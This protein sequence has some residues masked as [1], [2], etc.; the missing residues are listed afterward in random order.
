[1]NKPKVVVIAGPTASGK[2]ALAVELAKKINGEI[3]SADSMQIYKNM[4]IG[5]AKISEDEMQG[6]RHY[7]LDIIEPDK[8]Y[9]VSD[10]K[11]D[12]ENYIEKIIKEGKTPIICGGTGLYINSLIYGI[13]FQE[14]KI[15]QKYRDKLNKIADDGELEKL[16]NEA[17]KIDP[18][19]TKKI[20]KNDKKRII[21]ILEIY[22]TTGKTKTQQEIESKKGEIKYNYIVF[23]I[24]MK[25]ELLYERINKRVDQMIKNGLIEE[26]A[27]IIKKYK[28]FPTAMQGLGYKEIV[29]F[30]NGN[31]NKELM[32]EKIKMETRRYAKRQLTWFR[33]NKDII[34][35]D[36][37]KTK[38]ENLQIILSYI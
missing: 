37:E 23:T 12:A 36:G 18:E 8:R 38:E 9:S 15:D 33:K 25:R 29:E 32:I 1:M 19:A 26:V 17:L 4:N 5:T 16:Y 34:W 7:M 30:L 31:I 14:E 13:N 2:S 27:D 28:T 21:R 11:K 10:F 35:I 6:I 20:S 22:H 3:I 24:N